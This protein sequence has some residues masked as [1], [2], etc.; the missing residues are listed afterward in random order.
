MDAQNERLDTLERRILKADVKLYGRINEDIETAKDCIK[1][2]LEELDG[3][4]YHYRRFVFV[5]DIMSEGRNSYSYE[6]IYTKC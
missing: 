2:I 5:R 6:L 3:W 4:Q 1:D